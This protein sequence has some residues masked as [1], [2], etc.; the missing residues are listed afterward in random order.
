MLS[1]IHARDFTIHSF[2]T[3]NFVEKW[4]ILSH[5]YNSQQIKAACLQTPMTGGNILTSLET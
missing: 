4:L 2:R 5:F 1:V 3:T